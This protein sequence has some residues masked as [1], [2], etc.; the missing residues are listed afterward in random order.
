MEDQNK[1]STKKKDNTEKTV[2]F[3]KMT[4]IQIVTLR[5]KHKSYFIILKHTKSTPVIISTR[6]VHPTAAE[7]L[8][9][10]C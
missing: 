6:P 5:S 7:T 2:A 8:Q 9:I 3:S 10:N 4:S 1:I